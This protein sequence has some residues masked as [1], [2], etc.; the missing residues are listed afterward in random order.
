VCVAAAAIQVAS[1]QTAEVPRFFAWG[2]P[3]PNIAQDARLVY[4]AATS[5]REYATLSDDPAAAARTAAQRAVSQIAAGFTPFND[6]CVIIQDFGHDD[7]TSEVAPGQSR[8]APRTRFFQ[9]ADRL[10]ARIPGV[11][12]DGLFVI[13]GMFL[14]DDTQYLT[15]RTYRHPFLSRDFDP[16]DPYNPTKTSSTAILRRWMKDFVDEWKLMQRTTPPLHPDPVFRFGAALPNPSKFYFDT[17]AVI[18]PPTHR[19][20]VKML[21]ILSKIPQI[22]GTPPYAGWDVPGYPARTSLADLY[23]AEATKYGWPADLNDPNAGLQP[24]FSADSGRNRPFMLWY[25]RVAAAAKAAQMDLAAYTE[26]KS[27]FGPSC[28]AGNYNEMNLDGQLDLTGWFM[29]RNPIVQGER[30]PAQVF[31]RTLIHRQ[32]WGGQM[33]LVGTS[34]SGAPPLRWHADA[35]IARGDVD[36]PELYQT[37]QEQCLGWWNPNM[38]NPPQQYRGWGFTQVCHQQP[39]LYLPDAPTHSGPGIDQVDP[40]PTT[41]RLAR[42]AA[43]SIINSFGGGREYRLTPWLQMAKTEYKTRRTGPDSWD[44]HEVSEDEL[45]ALLAMLRAKNIRE[46]LFWTSWQPTDGLP[47]GVTPAKIT[48]TSGAIQSAYAASV[49]TFARTHGVVPAGSPPDDV[50]MLAFTLR[51]ISGQSRTLNIESAPTGESAIT[52]LQ[53]AFLFDTL[54][55]NG[56]ASTDYKYEFV[57]ECAVNQPGTKGR[58]EVWD[59]A[60]NAGQGAWVPVNTTE[61]DG[62]YNFHTPDFTS[63]RTF[64]LGSSNVREFVRNRKMH[65][66]YVHLNGPGTLVSKYDLTQVLPVRV[67]SDTG[68]ESAAAIESDANYDEVVDES[69]LLFY[70]SNWAEGAAGADSNMDEQ[71][72]DEDLLRFLNAYVTGT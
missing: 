53:V 33:T 44:L 52:E 24:D 38:Y 62:Q 27:A 5:A 18:A 36:S 29:N 45:R 69:D 9:E 13:D 8:Y 59:F 11:T 14:D 56:Y 21:W 67:A 51:D 20:V 15:N 54:G 64:T 37:T 57:V 40:F 66:K 10:E 55:V 41:M 72:D 68:E 49:L 35:S 23:A 43:E 3:I 25:Y 28:K 48:Q 34:G 7:P 12:I 58:V 42:H 6:V 4:M 47:P 63:R 50:A 39:D 17:E 65:V 60:G 61:G 26:V 1:A 30:E 2:A 31:P 71:V 16:L 70:L 19:N 32:P 46:A 22:W